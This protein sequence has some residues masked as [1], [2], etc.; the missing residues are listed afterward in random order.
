MTEEVVNLLKSIDN[1]LK[2]IIKEDS[3]PEIIRPPEIAERYGCNLN[4]AT[5]FC[6]LYGTRIGGYGIEKDKLKEVLQ[7]GGVGILRKKVK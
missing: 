6:K 1:K 2:Q 4:T 3:M 5:E 7:N